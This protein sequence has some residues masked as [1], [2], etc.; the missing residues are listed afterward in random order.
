MSCAGFSCKRQSTLKTHL[1][2]LKAGVQVQLHGLGVAQVRP[3]PLVTVPAQYMKAG[4]A[5]WEVSMETGMI[6]DLSQHATSKEARLVP[7]WLYALLV[8]I[9]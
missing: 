6:G 5:H 4:E 8:Q 2:L 3:I 7:G 1:E 9:D